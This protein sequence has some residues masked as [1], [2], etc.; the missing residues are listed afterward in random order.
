MKCLWK[1]I[2]NKLQTTSI[3]LKKLHAAWLFLLY[4]RYLRDYFYCIISKSEGYMTFFPYFSVF[5]HMISPWGLWICVRST[6]AEDT[7][8]S[9]PN[10]LQ[11]KDVVSFYVTNR[12]IMYMQ[13]YNLYIWSFKVRVICLYALM[14]VSLQQK[15]FRIHFCHSNYLSVAILYHLQSSVYKSIIV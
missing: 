7:N 10:Q 8:Q 15:W 1:C 2:F 3:N 4:L 14:F 5:L 13:Q 9:Y 6:D 11:G 12:I